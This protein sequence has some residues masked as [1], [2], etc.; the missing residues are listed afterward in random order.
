MQGARPLPNDRPEKC[1]SY[2]PVNVKNLGGGEA[3]SPPQL[4][5]TLACYCDFE[6]V[7]LSPLLQYTYM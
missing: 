2:S 7:T 1:G 4:D 3:S 6:Q 5:E